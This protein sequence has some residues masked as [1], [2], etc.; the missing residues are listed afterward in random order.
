MNV[1]IRDIEDHTAKLIANETFSTAK[2]VYKEVLV[3]IEAIQKAKKLT[4]RNLQDILFSAINALP[5]NVGLSNDVFAPARAAFYTAHIGTKAPITAAEIA[6]QTSKA[7]ADAVFL[8]AEKAIEVA[9]LGID[10]AAFFRAKVAKAKSLYKASA[11][12]TR[13]VDALAV[14]YTRALES[15]RTE[16]INGEVTQ[17]NRAV[18]RNRAAAAVQ[19][20]RTR[21]VAF[22][23]F[24]SEALE[25]YQT[26]FDWAS[27]YAFLAAQA[28]DYETGLLG[29]KD[30]QAFLGDIISSRALGVVDPDGQ[31]TLSAS[32][33]GD[34]GL[35]GLLAKLKSDYDVVKG[36][37]G[38]NNPETN[39]TTFSLRREW[40]RIPDTAEGDIAWQQALEGLVTTNLL[41]DADVA[42][43]AM[44][45]GGAEA[46]SQPGFL[47]AMP[48]LIED[49][50]NFFGKDLMARDSAYTSTNFATKIHSV[51]VVFEGYHGMAPCPMC[52]RGEDHEDA[53]SATP[54]VYLI[55]AGVDTMRTPP[56]G[57]AQAQRQWV[58]KD[59]AMPLPFDL[60]RFEPTPDA[61][62]QTTDSLRVSFREPRRHPAFRATDQVNNF[63]TGFAADYT[64]SRLVGRSVWN[65]NWK[66]AIPAKTL[67]ADE[68]EG[69]GRFIRSVKD[70]KLHLKT[71]SYS[72]N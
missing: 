11:A 17:A 39:G 16:V 9:N 60:G 12:R 31:P 69:I 55:P 56:L 61:V 52:Q 41:T 8:A 30:G 2:F 7:I 13:D 22:R 53:L 1:L 23:T 21:D 62:Q 45:L 50:K 49:G 43:H 15:Y 63:Y 59:Y 14:A 32:S 27:R 66:L 36:R 33:A 19:G 51:G 67:L 57:D 10:E 72:G 42:A 65:S 6:T 37:L 34:P 58:V 4:E 26:L 3:A 64:S 29:S 68:S 25:E 47:L 40:F 28:Y 48:S 18:F 35:S 24:R 44:Q 46:S 70:I 5:A 20:Y 71:Y 54:H 38:F